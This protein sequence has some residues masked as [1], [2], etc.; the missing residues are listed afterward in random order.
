MRECV[1]RI[2]P[3]E[4]KH[5]THFGPTDDQRCAACDGYT[6]RMRGLGDAVHAITSA[7]GIASVA[8]KLAGGNCGGCAARRAAMNAALPFADE[9]EK[10]D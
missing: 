1:F 6:G 2:V 8:N 10:K 7:T 3:T 5:P 9:R 4:C